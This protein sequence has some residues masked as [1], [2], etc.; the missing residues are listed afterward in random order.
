MFKSD[1]VGRGMIGRCIFT[2]LNRCNVIEMM[3]RVGER[4][5]IL[6]EPV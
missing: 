2:V 6:V 3:S 1:L 4:W 5:Q